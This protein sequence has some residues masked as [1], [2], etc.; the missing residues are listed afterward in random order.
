MLVPLVDPTSEC[1]LCGSSQCWSPLKIQLVLV[2][3]EDLTT[4]TDPLCGSSLFSSLSESSYADPFSGS[5]HCRF[6][7]S[8][9]QCW[10]PQCMQPVLV[11]SVDPAGDFSLCGS[12]QR[13]SLVHP[14]S[15][16]PLS[17]SLW[18]QPVLIRYQAY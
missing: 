5:N 12:S 1:P 13:S 10:S 2:L 7:S 11:P 17:R 18:I 15:A 8:S 3:I 9:S 14:A 6:L 16:G 4:S